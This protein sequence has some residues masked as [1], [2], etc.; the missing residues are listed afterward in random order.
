LDERCRPDAREGARWR[1]KCGTCAAGFELGP[2][3]SGCPDCRARGGSGLLELDLA[4]ASPPPAPR[5]RGFAR[6]LDR[7]LDL[8]PVID[9]AGWISLGE[10]GTA[11]VRSKAIGASLGLPNLWFKLEQQNPTLSFKDRFVAVTVNAARAL[12]YRRIVTSSTGN[13]GVSVAA[14]CAAAGLECLL[15]VPEETPETVFAEASLHG[16][17]IA[18]VD[19][20]VRFD[21][22]ELAARRPGWF[23]VGLFMNRPVQNPFGIEGYKTFAYEAIEA[24]GEAPDCMLFPCARG[25]GLYGAWKGFR[26]AARWGWCGRRPRMVACQPAV[27]NSLEASLRLRSPTAV[28]LPAAASIAASTTETVASDKALGAIRESGGTALSASDDEIREAVRLLGREGLSVESGSALTVACLPR[29][30]ASLGI[31]SGATIVCVLT[32]SGLRWPEQ[33]RWSPDRRV[34]ATSLDDFSRLLDAQGRA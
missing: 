14:Y 32:A 8:L 12:G 1:L 18:V 24:L 20:A 34:R 11:L 28:E 25:N 13:L 6:G 33:Q 30:R 9:T 10:G 16:A 22:L 15:I 7:Y 29:L 3:T 23:P 19:K 26:E 27:A 31:D 21:A 4:T 2:L 17:T 5:E